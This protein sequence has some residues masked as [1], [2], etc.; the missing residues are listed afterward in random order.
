MYVIII[1][2]NIT[3]VPTGKYIYTTVG[4]SLSNSLPRGKPRSM[5][6]PSVNTGI[7]QNR[8]AATTRVKTVISAQTSQPPHG[9]HYLPALTPERSSRGSERTQ[10]SGSN[11]S[12]KE[13][14][15]PAR[16]RLAA[17]SNNT[18]AGK[19]GKLQGKTHG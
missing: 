19:P 15:T 11:S 9:K 16:R 4:S 12:I 1:D 10:S 8:T 17:I 7:N 6:G 5:R 13:G 14:V 2:Q 3:L 18:T